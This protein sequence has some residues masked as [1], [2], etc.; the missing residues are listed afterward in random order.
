MIEANLAGQII[1][2]CIQDKNV[3][4]SGGLL[5]S[6][7]LSQFS[8]E[9]YIFFSSK[10]YSFSVIILILHYAVLHVADEMSPDIKLSVEKFHFS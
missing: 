9:I 2:M 4:F 8:Y 3:H 5:S 7:I 1:I 10:Y 6:K